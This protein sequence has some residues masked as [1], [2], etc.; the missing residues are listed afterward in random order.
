MGER[1]TLQDAHGAS[2]RI[3]TQVAVAGFALGLGTLVYV[4]DRSSASVPFFSAVSLGDTLPPVFGRLGESLPTFSHVFA[5]SVLTAAW[6]GGG[7]RAGLWACVGWFGVDTAFEAGQ[8]PQI[9]EGLVQFI[10]D[11]FEDLPILA[12]AGSYFVSGTFDGW[13][14]ISIAIG[15]AVAYIA[16]CWTSLRD[17]HRE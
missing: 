6:F 13:D 15:A 5:F 2:S 1:L 12:Q 14:L 17:D 3:W 16:V 7:T 10:P 11:W 4:L 8:H 9:A